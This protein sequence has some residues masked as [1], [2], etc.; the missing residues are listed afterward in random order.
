MADVFGD[1]LLDWVPEVAFDATADNH[2]AVVTEVTDNVVHSELHWLS[3][4]LHIESVG[5]YPHLTAAAVVAA[6]ATAAAADSQNC[7]ESLGD[8]HSHKTVVGQIDFDL[9]VVSD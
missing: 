8:H 9:D 7:L 3:A 5:F 2:S 1:R 6:A 4:D